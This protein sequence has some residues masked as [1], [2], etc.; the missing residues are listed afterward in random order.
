MQDKIDSMIS[1]IKGYLLSHPITQ[2]FIT[3]YCD[4]NFYTHIIDGLPSKSK[5]KMELRRRGLKPKHLHKIRKV[6]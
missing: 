5:V 2:K 4:P 3:V 1:D 6:K